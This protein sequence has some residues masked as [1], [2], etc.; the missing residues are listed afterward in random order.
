MTRTASER[1]TQGNKGDE[2]PQHSVVPVRRPIYLLEE[3]ARP[4]TA[5]RPPFDPLT[6]MVGFSYL[7]G[8]YRG[9]DPWH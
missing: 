8:V 7:D 9:V 1:A 2:Q 4:C 6:D 3:N 5:E